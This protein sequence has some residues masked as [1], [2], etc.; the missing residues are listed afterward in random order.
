MDTKQR[1]EDILTIVERLRSN[2][3]ELTEVD[4]SFTELNDG[5]AQLICN[6]AESSR[7]VASIDFSNNNITDDAAKNIYKSLK[8]HRSVTSLN[9]G[10]NIKISTNTIGMIKIGMSHKPKRPIEPKLVVPLENESQKEMF[11]VAKIALFEEFNDVLQY[12]ETFDGS[13]ENMTKESFFTMSKQTMSTMEKFHAL[14]AASRSSALSTTDDIT[15]FRHSLQKVLKKPWVFQNPKVGTVSH[16][17]Q[18]CSSSDTEVAQ[19]G[20]LKLGMLIFSFSTAQL[21][22]DKL[23]EI[24]GDIDRE[25]D[26]P[27]LKSLA[28]LKA[29]LRNA[30]EAL[31][32]ATRLDT[33][34]RRSTV[35][36]NSEDKTNLE[37]G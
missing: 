15:N 8:E 23:L 31:M 12:C 9:L 3:P 16:I 21:K 20:Q 32:M 7:H 30:E 27:L 4:L 25:E 33:K 18:Q 36:R 6:A 17:I 1:S 24:S 35:S 10:G 19:C 29:T 22:V 13:I 37:N 26:R 14:G 34:S 28:D 11:N 5:E 2:D